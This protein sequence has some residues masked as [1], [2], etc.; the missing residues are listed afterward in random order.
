MKR[1][2][3]IYEQIYDFAN[4]E[5][6]YKK[7]RRCKRYRSEVLRYSQNLEENLINLQNHLIWHSYKQGAY[8]TFYVY[9]PKKRLISALPF[10]DRVAQHAINNILEP[11]IDRRFYYHSYACRKG[12]GMH[13]ASDVLTKWIYEGTFEGTPLYAIKADIHHYFQSIDHD[14]L[15]AAIRRIIKDAETLALLDRIIDNGGENGKG[16]PVGNLTSQLFA[17]LYLD[18]LD[19]YVKETLHVRHYIRY[20]DDFVILSQDNARLREILRKIERFLASELGLLL[21]P[22]TTI[23]NCKNGVD[24]CGYRHFTDHKKVRKTSIR[25]MKRTIRAYRK[26]IISEERF[27]KALQSWLGHI[28]HADAYLLREGMFRQIEKAHTERQ[29]AET[30]STKQRE[31]GTANE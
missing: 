3:G 6:A 7:A 9:E 27:A 29:T 30:D 20:M 24:F 21:N 26:G 1:Y 4:L 25:R 2:N 12:K 23:L 22:K 19:K 18:R 14:R 5:C 10:T 17:N 15:K 13:K 31:G 16:I 11:L 8:R 28:Q